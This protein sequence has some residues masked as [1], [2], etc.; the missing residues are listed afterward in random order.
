MS[1]QR[2][3]FM[4]ESEVEAA[5]RAEFR[6]FDETE[7]FHSGDVFPAGP[8][9]TFRWSGD[10]AEARRLQDEHAHH[11]LRWTFLGTVAVMIV[12]LIGVGLSFFD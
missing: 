3:R 9:A 2:S 8:K 10:E 4:A 6:R 12:G 11:Y 7:T 1:W 5:W